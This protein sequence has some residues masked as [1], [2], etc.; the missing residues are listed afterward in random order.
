MNQEI[1][2]KVL[3]LN[4]REIS[5]LHTGLAKLRQQDVEYKKQAADDLWIPS[6]CMDVKRHR[7][8]VRR[9]RAYANISGEK[10]LLGEVRNMKDAISLQK[11]H[12]LNLTK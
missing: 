9:F 6:K 3:D 2:S 12:T 11:E 8:N 7:Y 4:G 5:A 10:K 1:I